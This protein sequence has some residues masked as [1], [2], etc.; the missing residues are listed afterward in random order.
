MMRPLV[1]VLALLLVA[2]AL[3]LATASYEVL[4]LG[5]SLARVVREARVPPSLAAPPG[6]RERGGPS[7][8]G[9]GPAAPGIVEIR[10]TLT[11]ADLA[12]LLRRRE[13]WLAG[14]LTVTRDV[15][16]R[17][18]AGRVVLETDNRIR[19]GGVTVARYPGASDW[20]LAPHPDGL[21]VRLNALRLSGI[22]VPGAGWLVRPFGR[23]ED[24]WTVVSTGVRHRIERIDVADGKLSVSGT[25]RGRA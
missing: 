18:T 10:F 11:E 12:R 17:L 24:G 15:S 4:G 21:A 6:S 2:G 20:S 16:A 14:V 19:V 13:R 5:A 1:A 25:V 8:P 22:R 23:P 3:V 7:P 9:A